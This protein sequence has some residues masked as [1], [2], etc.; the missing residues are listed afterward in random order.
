MCKLLITSNFDPIF[1]SD[2]GIKRRGLSLLFT[3]RFV[4]P[5]DYKEGTKGIYKRNKNLLE[6]FSNPIK[7]KF[8]L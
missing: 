8:I 3:N 4:D 6:E 5:N 1:E 7:T 2:E